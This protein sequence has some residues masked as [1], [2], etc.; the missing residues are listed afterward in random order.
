MRAPM[1]PRAR[2][3]A[4]AAAL[5]AACALS[6][7]VWVG[8]WWTI[9]EVA[10]GPRG[11]HHCFGGDCRASDLGWTGGSDLWMRSAIATWAGGLIAMFVL[12]AVAA[13]IVS[14]RVPRL[15]AKTALVALATATAAGTTFIAARPSIDGVAIGYGLVLFIVALAAG[16]VSAVIVLRTPRA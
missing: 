16:V 4:T 15:L 3:I 11:T 5:A 10:L 6:L 9:G 1:T 8:Q 7:S 14:R 13:A 2:W 12:I